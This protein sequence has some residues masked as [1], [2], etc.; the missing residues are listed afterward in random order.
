MTERLGRVTAIVAGVVLAA[1]C[2]LPA[3]PS[4]D[5]SSATAQPDASEVEPTPG[6]D[7][8]F[9]I[10]LSNTVP[11]SV[12]REEMICAVK[13]EAL[14]SEQ[15]EALT[16]LNRQTDAA[17]Q[18]DD[19]RSLIAANVDAIVLDP[20]DPMALGDVI[21][22]ATRAGIVVVAVDQPLESGSAYTIAVDQEAVGYLSASWLFERL[23]GRG[24]IVYVRGV[25]GSPDDEARHQGFLRALSEYPDVAVG[26]ELFA[27][28]PST[29]PGQ[30]VQ[31]LLDADPAVHG[32]LALEDSVRASG[33]AAAF[34]RAFQNSGR[35][36][37]PIVATET[38]EF[39]GLL[40][41]ERANGLTGAV[42][43]NPPAIGGAGTALAMQALRGLQPDQRTAIAPELLAN[44][45]S[46]GVAQLLEAHD[47]ELDP[48]YL[49]SYTIPDWTTYAKSDLVD[50]ADLP[51]P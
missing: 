45:S 17:G 44:T 23:R 11:G 1:A 31:E 7:D 26:R 4:P 47:P 3:L 15:V 39:V 16:I 38:N 27:T 41:A 32:I 13:A 10:G 6:P 36:Y 37:R 29:P 49:V 20:V 18:I 8:A 28:Q 2:T 30:Q 48:R 12:W 33:L 14:A 40:E 46:E 19:I 42:V 35:D 24:S 43:T 50:C 22:E 5:A 9:H 25:R 21:D 51:A 34:V